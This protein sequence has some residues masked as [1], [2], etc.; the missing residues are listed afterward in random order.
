MLCAM[1]LVSVTSCEKGKYRD[2]SCEHN[3]Y[4]AVDLGLS[5][6]TLWATCNVGA[7]VPNQ[8]GDFFAWGEITTK[9]TYDWT[10]YQWCNYDES[11]RKPYFTKYFLE[12]NYEYDGKADNISLLEFS[13]DAA[14]EN[15]G[16]S[17]RTPTS[18]EVEELLQECEWKLDTINK[19]FYFIKGPNGNE[20]YLPI[21]EFQNNKGFYWT[22]SLNTDLPC[23]VPTLNID[24]NSHRVVKN[25]FRYCGRCV[26]PVCSLK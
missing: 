2:N 11:T 4:D 10:T 22:S 7:T 15:W 18:K 20:I 8:V 19:R 23:S 16:G 24:K 1:M 12:N 6:G 25:S 5:S 21:V 17:W 26:R 9:S 14:R 13:D 3:G